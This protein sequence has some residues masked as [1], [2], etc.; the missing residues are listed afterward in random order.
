MTGSRGSWQA[1]AIAWPLLFGAIFGSYLALQF[2]ESW[3]VGPAL[4]AIFL[5]SLCSLPGGALFGIVA[6]LVGRGFLAVAERN[7]AWSSPLA[8]R[9]AFA[10]A[11]ALVIAMVGV[12]ALSVTGFAGWGA[13]LSGLGVGAVA[14]V[15]ALSYYPAD[16]FRHGDARA[17]VDRL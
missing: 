17:V 6:V 9:L 15:A 4:M 12:A 16:S 1:R 11:T 5:G 13:V 8:W 7:A 14:F 2:G 3:E 10:M